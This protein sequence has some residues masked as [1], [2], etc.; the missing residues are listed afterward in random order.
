MFHMIRES[1]HPTENEGSTEL[2]GEA[3]LPQV[4]VDEIEEKEESVKYHKIRPRTQPE[5]VPLAVVK[6]KSN[7]EAGLDSKS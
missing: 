3:F 7:L 4:L 6:S 2:T 5:A 1:E